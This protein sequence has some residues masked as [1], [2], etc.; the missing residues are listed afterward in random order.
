MSVF[1][2]QHLSKKYLSKYVLEDVTFS[3]TQGHFYILMAPNGAG[4]S[5]VLRLIMG[6]ERPTAGTMS[7]LES[8]PDQYGIPAHLRG[9]IGL[10]A[11][12]IEYDPSAS[13]MRF[14]KFYAT[15]FPTY[16]LP[17]LCAMAQVRNI[18][19]TQKFQKL[20]RGQKMQVIL[21]SELAKRPKL[22]LID[23]ITSVLD[24]YS[25]AFYLN[26]LSDFTHQGG[27]VLLTT[28]VIHEVESSASDL[29][30]LKGGTVAWEAPINTIF[31]QFTKIMV[32]DILTDET[33]ALLQQ[34]KFY[35]LDRLQSDG[36]WMSILVGPSASLPL[37]ALPY[38]QI[39][40]GAEDL[41]KYFFQTSDVSVE[42]KAKG[43][44]HRAA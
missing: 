35:P 23:E 16:D 9:Q 4:K 22:L 25:R 12:T 5:T 30:I 20:S 42:S 21:L 8:C 31:R 11:E 18:D 1:S 6:L 13:L 28:N 29:L 14:L 7:F 10:V 32:S 40:M 44:D 17:W 41:F 24:P 33:Q 15:L 26:L 2:C 27:T 36:R 34:H 37:I 3:L 38:V 43:Y 19:L 39:H